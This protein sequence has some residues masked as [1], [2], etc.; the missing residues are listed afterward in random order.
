VTTLKTHGLTSTSST[1]TRVKLGAL[2]E[3][4][5]PHLEQQMGFRGCRRFATTSAVSAQYRE[6]AYVRA[7]AS[8]ICE[9]SR[10]LGGPEVGTIRKF[11]S[12]GQSPINLKGVNQHGC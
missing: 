3:T 2:V 9:L 7:C 6:R 12:P 8:A 4:E 1:P 11:L 5:N 10:Q